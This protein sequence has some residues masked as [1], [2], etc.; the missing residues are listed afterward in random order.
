MTGVFSLLGF[1]LHFRAVEK[2][3]AL[4]EQAILPSW[5]SPCATMPR[6]GDRNIQIW[7][8]AAGGIDLK[9]RA[10]KY[11]ETSRCCEPGELRDS[12][13]YHPGATPRDCWHRE[14]DRGLSGTRNQD[15]PAAQ[16]LLP[17]AM[18]AKKEIEPIAKKYFRAAFRGDGLH[19]TGVHET[20]AR[21]PSWCGNCQG[22]LSTREERIAR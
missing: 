9:D 17:S 10:T 13:R 21:H 19:G 3:L 11:P 6:S 15:D 7:L 1:A 16:F 5:P 12:I 8:E 20:V 2:D 14:R 4:A 18:Q 22:S